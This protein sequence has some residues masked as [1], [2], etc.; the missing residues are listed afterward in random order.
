[1]N[2]RLSVVNERGD[3]LF[4]A[5]GEDFVQLDRYN[6]PYRAGDRIVLEANRPD[7]ELE[8][9]LDAGML[10]S[11][12][13][14]KDGRLEL[15]VPFDKAR[16]PYGPEAFSGNRIWGYAR[17]ITDAERGNY[18]NLALNSHD[19]IDA[20]AVFPHAS[21]NSG[22]TDERFQARNAIDG[23]TQ[24]CLHGAWPYGSWGT[25]KRDDAW[26]KID[27]GR[28][29]RA[30]E[31]RLFLRADYPHDSWWKHMTITSSNGESRRVD[32]KRT[33]APQVFRLAGDAIEWLRLEQLV[34]G[35]ESPFPALSQIQVWGTE[36]C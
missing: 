9:M 10:P 29:V 34:R 19:L 21:T 2:L 1:M 8:V 28:P 35:D 4:T 14:L 11:I 18:R 33:G 13:F 26:L 3:A 12:V 23:V 31:I 36:I 25:N 27:F 15:P 32:L 22:A 24:T 6:E 20:T 5:E 17:V 7:V 30:Q 16:R